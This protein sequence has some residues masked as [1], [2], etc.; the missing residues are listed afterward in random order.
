MHKEVLIPIGVVVLSVAFLDPFMYLMPAQL[1]NLCIALL[2]ILSFMY[3]LLIW[4]ERPADER[5]YMHRAF[6]GRM[7]YLAGVIVLVVGIIYQA[8]MLHTVDVFLVV[9]LTLMTV[10]KYVAFLHAQ[11]RN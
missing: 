11:K 2:L 7:A 8:L 1:V 4:R 6:A 10:A 3:S 5:E 9:A